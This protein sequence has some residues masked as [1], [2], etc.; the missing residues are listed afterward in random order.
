MVLFKNSPRRLHASKTVRAVLGLGL[1]WM[2]F[3]M[4]FGMT[5]CAEPSSDTGAGE[6]TGG[7]DLVIWGGKIATAGEQQP[8]VEALAAKDGKIVAVGTRAEIE[9]WVSDSTEVVDLAGRLAI[10]GFV[11]SHAHYLSIGDA[12]IQLPL[13]KAETWTEIVDMVR[14]AAAEAEPGEWIRGR[15]WHQDKW[16]DAPGRVVNEFPTHDDL[17]AAA[18]ENPVLLTHASGHAILANA[19][20]MRLAGIDAN[21]PDP[22]GGDIVRDELGEASGM[23]NETAQG[24]IHR[25]RGGAEGAASANEARKMIKMAGDECRSKGVTSFHDA[26]SPFSDV[27]A[28]RKAADEGQLGTR[29]WVMVE[30][31]NDDLAENLAAYKTANYGDHDV[32]AVGGIKRYMDGA[33]GSRGAWLLAP[34]DDDPDTVG[35]QLSE[36]DDLRRTAELARQHGYQLATH[37]I[38]DRANREVLDVYAEALGGGDSATETSSDLRW[39]VEHAQHLDPEDIPRF[40]ELGVIASMQTVHCTSDGPWVPERIGDERSEAG[41]Y[42][43]Q[44]L[45][46]TGATVINGTDAPVEDVDPIANYHSAVTRLMKNGETFYP[47]QA[48][49]RLEA[50][51][52][53]T[54]DG[55]Y[56]AFQEDLVGSLEVGK[57]ADVVVLSKDILT[58][59]AEE[60]RDTKVELTIMGG[61][62]VYRR[63]AE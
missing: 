42:V 9:G 55:A 63:A 1:G 30:G 11:E 31:S 33:L 41:A 28:F 36:L 40:A 10:P 51:R 56:G 58:V 27:D 4:A 3:G 18:P 8:E 25:A 23:F 14:N 43:W 50:L 5:G 37:A 6:P 15:G 45:R 60:I 21:T 49:G 20:A 34:Y 24:L 29:L 62:V 13:A 54:L 22:A 12:R 32:L 35:L 59:P 19:E 39:R 61:E 48:L 38:G 47:D 57:L 26:G 52:S 44:K 2:V 46:Q 17:T 7:A 53:M 16:A